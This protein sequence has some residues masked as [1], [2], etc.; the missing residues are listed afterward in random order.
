MAT[1]AT[2]RLQAGDRDVVLLHGILGSRRNWHSFA[3]RLAAA[4]PDLGVVTV[5]IRNHGDS[6]GFSPPHG[7]DA[8][9]ADLVA[10]EGQAFS[11]WAIV[12]HSFGGKVALRL[13]QSPARRV[14]RQLVWLAALD[15][16]PGPAAD[17]NGSTAP[18]SAEVTGVIAAL[19]Q[20]PRP[21]VSREAMV[22][23]LSAAGLSPAIG[24]W[25]T[26]NLRPVEGGFDWRFD[27]D[28]AVAMLADYSA[29][30]VWPTLEAPPP[31]LT[32]RFLRAGRAARWSAADVQRLETIDARARA[33]GVGA[34]VD[35]LD[36]GHWLHAEAPDALL[37][38]LLSALPAVDSRQGA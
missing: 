11:T 4:R 23:T 9:V 38:W 7:L 19:R 12:G 21:V 31:E 13:A 36:A 32:V 14:M 37:A 30:D 24:Q 25:M 2:N 27:L 18:A 28:A 22:S 5:D 29:I 20:V 6:Q 35:T 3:A 16:T 1:L 10:S 8:C 17:A 15:C 34:R 33:T 26:T